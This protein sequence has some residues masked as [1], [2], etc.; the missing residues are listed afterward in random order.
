MRSAHPAPSPTLLLTCEHA[1]NR[2]P[3]A[4][5]ALF[6]PH[7]DLLQ[8]HRGWDPGALKLAAA[9][10]K[11][12]SAP[13]LSTP[14]TRLLIE[15]NRS[16]HHP[17]LFSTITR[18]LDAATKS[19]I[20]ARYYTPHR[21]AIRNELHRLMRTST[22]VLHVGVHTFTPVLNGETRSA[23]IGLLYDPRRPAEKKLCERWERILNAIDPALR[24]RRNYPYRGASDGLT[25]ALRREFPVSKYLGIEL[26][27]NQTLAAFT[28]ANTR[29]RMARTI[30]AS[31]NQLLDRA[32]S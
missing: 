19:L 18:D 5:A 24:V 30:I 17:A 32:P 23:D 28:D 21:E 1:G 4:Y 26:E 29:R 14:T 31:M 27:V 22:P 25:T 15:P 6:R 10:A 12:L 7:A 20:A 8:S 16:P 9:L 3:R 2:V 11:S 13:L